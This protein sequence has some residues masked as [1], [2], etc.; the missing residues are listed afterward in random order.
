MGALARSSLYPL[1]PDSTAYPRS[2]S[3]SLEPQREFRRSPPSRVSTASLGR[4]AAASLPNG[5]TLRIKRRGGRESA[6]RLS[7]KQSGAPLSLPLCRSMSLY[8][9]LCR[10]PGHRAA[11]DK[12][13][14]SRRR[15]GHIT[16]APGIMNVLATSAR[17]NKGRSGRTG[18]GG[19]RGR[20]NNHESRE[21]DE[22]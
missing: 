14:G 3:L 10:S 18:G 16:R 13:A 9:A 21:I 22:A 19:T 11:S 8:V 2:R 15:Y 1:R 7:R 12:R 5:G 17:S 4:A 20:R 6:P